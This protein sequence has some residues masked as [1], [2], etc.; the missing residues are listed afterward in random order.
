MT[1]TF[2]PQIPGS[3]I[4]P[5]GN[6]LA[7]LSEIT[8][9]DNRAITRPVCGEAPDVLSRQRITEILRPV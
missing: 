5:S 2:T 6:T 4:D 9:P 7:R 3:V 1:L 8:E